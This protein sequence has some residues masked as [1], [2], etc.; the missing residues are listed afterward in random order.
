M[1][2]IFLPSEL[3][4]G[5]AKI[6]TLHSDLLHAMAVLS[7]KP[8]S[9]FGSEYASFITKLERTFSTEERW[10]EEIDYPALQNHREQHA[11]VLSAM[12]ITH[13]HA[14]AGDIT[15][16]RDVIDRLLPYWLVFHIATA[17]TALA[18]VMQMTGEQ[19]ATIAA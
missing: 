16:A 7:A 13:A 11:R 14:L 8:S 15:L 17:D 9:S 12:H 18:V 2:Q 19:H 1:S 6:D 5:V 4:T 10:M 3:A